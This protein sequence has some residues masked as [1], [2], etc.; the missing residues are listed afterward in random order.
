MEPPFEDTNFLHLVA[1]PNYGERGAWAQWRLVVRMD[2]ASTIGAASV[3]V[4]PRC[5]YG[6]SGGACV[7][8]PG[9]VFGKC[10]A[11]H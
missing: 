9:Y 6:S 3:N 5:T 8:P 7:V 10:G 1:C 4:V 2:D 11:P